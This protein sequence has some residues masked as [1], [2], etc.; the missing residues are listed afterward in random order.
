MVCDLPVPGGPSSTKLCP[1]ADATTAALIVS[2]YATRFGR[3]VDPELA[4]AATTRHDL[5]QRLLEVWPSLGLEL[6]AL[7]G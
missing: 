6:L 4:L 1:V 3:D 7:P 2:R 5:A